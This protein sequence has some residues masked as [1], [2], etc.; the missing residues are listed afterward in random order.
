MNRDELLALREQIVDTTRQL[1][2]DGNASTEDKIDILI[3]L[4]HSGD[5]SPELF[6]RAYETASS[7]ESDDKKMDAMLDLL[8]EV[9]ARIS[10]SDTENASQGQT[11]EAAESGD[12][13]SA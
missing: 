3:G 12:Q 1:A 9:D 2:L 11:A 13:P 7:L 10:A 6:H 8:Y 5:S 4:I